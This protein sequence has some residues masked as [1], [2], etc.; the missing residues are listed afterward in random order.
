LGDGALC[1]DYG[2]F[3]RGGEAYFGTSEQA[4]PPG[5]VGHL[6]HRSLCF[7]GAEGLLA[8]GRAIVLHCEPGA[9]RVQ[10]RWETGAEPEAFAIER[11]PDSLRFTELAAGSP[12]LFAEGLG[13]YRFADSAALGAQYYRVRARYRDGSSR[14]SPP[15]RGEALPAPPAGGDAGFEWLSVWPNPFQNRVSARFRLSRPQELRY[16]LADMSG[17]ALRQG[18]LSAGGEVQELSL[19]LPGLAAGRYVW[20][21]FHEQGASHQV[22]ICRP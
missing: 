19:D 13:S 15:S 7:N 12:G 22:L 3:D 21:V 9:G 6:S 2:A 4:C 20:T 10:L 14:Y 1:S 11:G 8:D 5:G 16:V 17:R 18:S